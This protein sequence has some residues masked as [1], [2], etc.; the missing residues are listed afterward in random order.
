MRVIDPYERRAV[1]PD[2]VAEIGFMPEEVVYTSIADGPHIICPSCGSK[3]YLN[4]GII[5]WINPGYE[6]AMK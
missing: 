1:C 6:G 2:C 5:Q 4:S 3:V